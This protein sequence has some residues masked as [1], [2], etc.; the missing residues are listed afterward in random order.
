MKT[1]V[2]IDFGACYIKAAKISP[3]IKRVQPIKL[4]MNIAGGVAIPAAILYDKIN[5]EVEV[6]V[7]EGAQAS[8]DVENKISRL[9]PKLAVKNWSKYIPNLDAKISAADALKDI[10]AKIWR[11]IANQAARD[12]N[13]DVTV[14]VPAAFSDVQKKIIRQA[15]I[16]ADVPISTIITAPFAEIFSR[17]E[18]FQ[19]AAQIVMIFDF[20][21]TTLDVTLF[22]LSRT[23]KTFNVTELS[24]AT[25]NYGGKNID[26]SILKN[27]FWTKYADEVKIFRD[28]PFEL[29]TLIA[30]MK[31]EIFLD[32]E[33][34]SSG[35]LID[36][37][38]NLYEFE[39]T[40]QEI[41]TAIERDG[42]KEKIIAMLDDVLDDAGISAEEVVAVEVSGGTSSIE[43][44]L[45][46]LENYFGEEIF[47]AENFERDEITLGAA[48]GAAR[49]RKLTDEDNLRV[50]V[51]NVVPCGIYIQRGEKYLR[52]IRRN[53]LRG[54]ITP[55]KPISTD[56]LKKNKWRLSIYQSFCNEVELPAESGDA[57]Y[58]GDVKIDSALYETETI[59]FKMQVNAAGQVCVKFFE[60]RNVNGRSKIVFVEERVLVS[61][62]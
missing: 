16:Q 13:F 52:C 34:I 61:S 12:E 40:R 26:E 24:A 58:I 49:Y 60:D 3:Q 17:E 59:L 46:V 30:S 8:V 22:E 57:V 48:I 38:G 41:F 43:Y 36:G 6:K 47:D 2:G 25:L 4:N 42:V 35:S 23:A 20:G 7:G 15:A 51:K 45:D 39:L 37:K 18:I 11:H 56:E 14:T 21:A 28:K 10:F 29:M 9:T 50:K 55:Y 32:E 53:E 44:F 27:I 62:K 33:E 54:F 31:E 5:G 1:Y 19:D